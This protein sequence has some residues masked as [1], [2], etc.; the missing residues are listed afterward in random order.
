[1]TFINC[2]LIFESSIVCMD[3]L[4]SMD[5][6]LNLQCSHAHKKQKQEKN[7]WMSK[8][9][10]GLGGGQNLIRNCAKIYL[11]NFSPMSVV[12]SLT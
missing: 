5:Q 12:L 3:A 8:K 11:A 9:K 4:C 2:A 6:F 7:G 10:Q 1:M